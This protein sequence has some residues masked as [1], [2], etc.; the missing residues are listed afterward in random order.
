M[1]TIVPLSTAIFSKRLAV[2]MPRYAQIVNYAEAAFFGVNHP[3]NKLF[4][5]REI[6]SHDQRIAIYRALQEAQSEVEKTA[7]FPLAP[8]WIGPERHLLGSPVVLTYG[9]LIQM[10]QLLVTDLALAHAVVIATDPATVTIIPSPVTA[11]QIDEVHIYHP[12]TDIEIY[13]SA[14]AI[15]GGNLVISIPLVRMVAIAYEN[16]PANGL[17][18]SLSPAWAEV[19]LDVK[20]ESLSPTLPDVQFVSFGCAGTCDCPESTLYDGCSYVIDAD[21]GIIRVGSTGCLC[22][23]ADTGFV[24]VYYQAGLTSLTPQAE[25]IIVRLAHSRM[26]NEPCGCD[27]L[28]GRWR[29]DQLVPEILTAERENCPYGLSAGAWAAWTYAQTIKQYRM[30]V[31]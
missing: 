21:M 3:D 30:G 7:E 19:T 26:A 5:C 4:E 16:T 10:G 28:K 11:A 15:V 24:D 20:R 17:T 18:Y 6:W 25:D 31:I 13:P 2:S 1:T 27:V 29:G 22:I 23:P 9:K 8:T 12:G 14:I